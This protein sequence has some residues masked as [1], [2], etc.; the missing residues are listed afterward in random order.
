M[1]KNH[2]DF[3]FFLYFFLVIEQKM[4]DITSKLR[5]RIKTSNQTFEAML[6]S[7][8]SDDDD[9]GALYYVVAVVMIYG[10]SIV[11]MIA[12]HIRRNN[13]DN[14]L[15]SYLKEMSLL[16]K[17]DRRERI[18]TRVAN[19]SSSAKPLLTKSR[20]SGKQDS[21]EIGTLQENDDE[22]NDMRMNSN[23]DETCDSVFQMSCDETPEVVTYYEAQSRMCSR[24]SSAQIQVIDENVSLW[25][26]DVARASPFFFWMK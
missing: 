11:M 3:N 19:V 4:M 8:K 2:F 26:V 13:Q 22:F 17:N 25:P 18:F 10:L 9:L 21:D 15:R 7:Y 14:Q 6:D 1:F 5:F 24:T 20:N 16:R 12:S 23:S